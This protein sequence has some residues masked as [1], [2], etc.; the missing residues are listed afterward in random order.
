VTVLEAEILYW[1]L[2]KGDA[3]EAE[4]SP[5]KEDF[6]AEVGALL[7]DH[8]RCCICDGPV[9]EP[10]GCLVSLLAAGVARR[11]RIELTVVMERHFARDLSGN[12]SP[13][14]THATGP[15]ELAKKKM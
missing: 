13:V 2:H 12:N 4:C 7:V 15:Q 6:A 10:V 11:D 14:T 1:D 5:D 8:V 3:D 9:E